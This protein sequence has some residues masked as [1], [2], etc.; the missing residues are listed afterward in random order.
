MNCLLQTFRKYLKFIRDQSVR[1]LLLAQPIKRDAHRVQ[2]RDHLPATPIP[3]LFL[4]VRKNRVFLL[5]LLTPLLPARLPF[6]ASAE[7]ADALHVFS[8][9]SDWQAVW[10]MPVLERPEFSGF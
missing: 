10:K 5:G 9:A 1:Y 4:T 7:T 2:P 3:P 6:L 8:S